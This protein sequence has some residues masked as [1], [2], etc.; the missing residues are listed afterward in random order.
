[1]RYDLQRRGEIV[2]DQE[3]MSEDVS[4][5][6]EEGGTQEESRETPDSDG[7]AGRYE[8]TADVSGADD[9]PPRHWDLLP[10]VCLQHVLFWLG[11]QDRV[12]A[13]LVCCR[14]HRATR[15]PAL[16][17][18]RRF[19]FTGLISKTLRTEQELAVEYVRSLGS[20]LEVLEVEVVVPYL[21][22]VAKVRRIQLTICALLREL[23]SARARLRSLTV[24]NLEL[25]RDFWMRGP[26]K[27]LVQSLVRFLRHMAPHLVHLSLWGSRAILQDG[28]K[29]LEALASTQQHLDCT[30]DF[31]SGIVTLDLE[32]FFSILLQPH[33][34]L[35]MPCHLTHIH[36]LESLTLSYS[37]VTDELLN[38][39]G[40]KVKGPGRRSTGMSLKRLRL[41]CHWREPHS[42]VV[43]G[44]EWAS[45]V[46]RCPQLCTEIDIEGITSID[47]LQRILLPE[48]PLT[49]FIMSECN[50]SEQ[51]IR[52]K[53]IFRDILPHYCSRLQVGLGND[54]YVKTLNTTF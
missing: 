9:S 13:S 40:P 37:C 14:W 21:R 29:I 48:V 52:C 27:A 15:S 11:D 16:W 1:M 3:R 12:R 4:P 53:A 44:S 26:T 31:P 39:L 38:A 2:C 22:V 24:R 50:F 6:Q 17:R 42:Q 45:L 8:L 33:D 30:S 5:E 49:T 47:R 7:T 23:C 51:D 28:L 36:R 43:C 19:R 18:H 41:K 35:S 10:D 32:G 20:F 34:L 54:V 25:Q 46:Q